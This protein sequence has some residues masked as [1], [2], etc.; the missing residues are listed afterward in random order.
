MSCIFQKWLGYDT[1]TDGDIIHMVYHTVTQK[2]FQRMKM[3]PKPF[4]L[5]APLTNR[6][7]VAT[8][9]HD[10]LGEAGRREG[11]AWPE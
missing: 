4:G 1:A 10:I 5:V 3:V 9:Q 2:G 7:L 8:P 6:P 11:E